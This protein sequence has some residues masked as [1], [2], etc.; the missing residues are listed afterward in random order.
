METRGVATDLV[1][2]VVAGGVATALMSRVT[3]AL[4]AR[5][6]R[7]TR[8]REN[9]ARGGSDTNA[10][11]ARKAAGLLGIELSGD[12]A[13]MAGEAAHYAIGTGTAAVYGVVRRHIPAPTV[14]RGLGFGAALWLVAD[15]IGNPALG[16]TPGPGAFPWQ[17]HARG[18]AAHLVY[19]LAAEG[20]L[21]VAD[22]FLPARPGG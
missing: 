3:S 6:G 17:A 5:E 9:R 22:R 1:L 12:R 16:V 11:A 7:A 18:L 13:A 4:Y 14:V 21:T 10:I 20:V 19:G 15:E 2:G 8:W